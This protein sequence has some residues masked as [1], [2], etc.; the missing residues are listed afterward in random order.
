MPLMKSSDL[1][2][3]CAFIKWILLLQVFPVILK[4]LHAQCGNYV[5]YG[6]FFAVS[7]NLQMKLLP[8]LREKNQ[9]V[10]L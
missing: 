1:S 2:L 10:V 4:N 3:K 8:V 9:T 7:G 5:E 6:I